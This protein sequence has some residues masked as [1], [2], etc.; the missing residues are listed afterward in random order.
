M[1]FTIVPIVNI[2]TIVTIANTV[3]IPLPPKPNSPPF[4]KQST[5][6]PANYVL[7]HHVIYAPRL[8][9]RIRTDLLHAHI[10]EF[11][12]FGKCYAEV[13]QTIAIERIR[14]IVLR[15]RLS[16][17]LTKLCR[18]QFRHCA[19][20]RGAQPC[21]ER[22]SKAG[23]TTIR[24]YSAPRSHNITMG[25]TTHDVGLDVWHSKSRAREGS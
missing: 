16:H 13:G 24:R 5:P 8:A 17:H 3:T 21:D 6:G 14:R 18:G 23:A 10:I 20:Q 4:N 22:G 1:S 12:G 7:A 25:T 2:A 9:R 15:S 19:P 11:A